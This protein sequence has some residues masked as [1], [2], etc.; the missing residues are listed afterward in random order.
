MARTSPRGAGAHL[1]LSL[2]LDAQVN[3]YYCSSTDSIG[4][5]VILSNPIET[6][7]V[8]DF[9]SLL[10]PGI[11]ARFSITPSVREATSSLRSIS[12]QNR[13]CYFLNERRLLYYRYELFIS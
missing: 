6:P 11:E 5:K 8:A 3:D 13:Q 7:K 10:S 2:V 12:I 4:F 1:G 9:G